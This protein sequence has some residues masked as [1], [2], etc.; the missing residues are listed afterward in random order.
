MGKNFDR[1]MSGEKIARPR[2]LRNISDP[3]G[4]REKQLEKKSEIEISAR[5]APSPQD[6]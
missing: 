5:T 2:G 3:A 4:L 6:D 1:P